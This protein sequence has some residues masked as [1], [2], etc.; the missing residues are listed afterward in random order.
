MNVKSEPTPNPNA[1]KFTSQDGPLF[2]GRVICKQGD[3]PD[4]PLLKQLLELEGVDNL[5]GFQDFLTVN[6]TFDAQWDNLM[7]KIEEAFEQNQ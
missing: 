2:E 7:P 4:H 6:K 5:F 1:M 3:N